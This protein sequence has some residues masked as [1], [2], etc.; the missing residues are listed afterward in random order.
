MLVCCVLP[1]PSWVLA[2]YWRFH[3]AAW[4]ALELAH[5]H[6]CQGRRLQGQRCAVPLACL[7]GA[8]TTL[9]DSY[10]PDLPDRLRTCTSNNKHRMHT[11]AGV[12][13]IAKQDQYSDVWL[14]RA[15][16]T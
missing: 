16:H 11:Y 3:R 10:H 15:H 7:H 5:G 13:S 2:R 8:P 6:S 4:R 14:I 1:L 12:L 9:P